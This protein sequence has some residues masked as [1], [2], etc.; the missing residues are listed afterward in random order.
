MQ[1]HQKVAGKM[2]L[3]DNLIMVQKAFEIYLYNIIFIVCVL[4]KLFKDS[5]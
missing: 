1:V 5:M 2:E 4:H 3:K